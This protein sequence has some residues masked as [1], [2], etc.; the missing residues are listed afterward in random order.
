MHLTK[1]QR[2][3]HKIIGS[4]LATETTRQMREGLSW[5]SRLEDSTLK[6]AHTVMQ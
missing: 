1:I 2:F 4:D 5:R 3:S 6:M